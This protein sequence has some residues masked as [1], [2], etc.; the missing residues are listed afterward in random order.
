VRLRETAEALAAMVAKTPYMKHA[1]HLIFLQQI[2]K[3]NCMSEEELSAAILSLQITATGGFKAAAISSEAHLLLIH[4]A[5]KALTTLG[6]WAAIDT[7]KCISFVMSRQEKYGYSW[8]AE[9][10]PPDLY[11]TYAGISNLQL[12]RAMAEKSIGR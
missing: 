11:S 3:H 2:L 9:A 12:L 5:I 6:S 1:R 4:S 8:A 10:S 7:D